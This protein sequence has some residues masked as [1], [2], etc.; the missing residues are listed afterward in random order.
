ML[1][2]STASVCYEL[3]RFRHEIAAEAT[4]L[5]NIIGDACAGWL[6]FQDTNAARDTLGALR[7]S[8]AVVS[9]RLYRM[10]GSFFAE[11][12]RPGM[13]VP[14]VVPTPQT[15]GLWF[16]RGEV[17]FERVIKLNNDPVGMIRLRMDYQQQQARLRS[18]VLIA[19]VVI[20][21]SL[22]LALFVAQR[23]QRAISDPLLALA[24]VTREVAGRADFSLRA[25]KQSNDEIGELVDGFNQMLAK[26]QRGD[27]ALRGSEERFRQVAENIRE[28]FW[29]TNVTKNEMIYISSAYEEIWGRPVGD[30]YA[31]P[32]SWLAA[33]HHEDRDR[34]TRAAM[35]RQATG[36][37][38]E[39]Y[40]I[41]RPDGSIRWIRDRAFPVR[42]AAG[43]VYRL[44]G[45]AEDITEQRRVAT[46]LRDSEERL[47]SILDN[48]PAVIYVKDASGRYLLVNRRYETLFHA[49]RAAII[50]K[51]DYD[52]CSRRNARTLL[53]TTTAKCSVPVGPCSLRKS[54][55]TKTDCTPTSR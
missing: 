42:D 54:C 55:R 7:A 6:A 27:E 18:Y 32:R 48:S 50:G 29:M 17:A 21:L 36:E 16:E 35:T 49:T 30:L 15:H 45:L 1:L 10:D 8:P 43:K 9:A 34:V 26:I 25:T 23:L 13:D 52:F 46:A 39:Q 47:Q 19:G 20:L 2:G 12:V 53:L 22:F 37:Y 3:V 51:T 24:R 14:R 38:D 28:V 33:I 11:Y 4:T 44:A 40:R 41:V 31:E 5:G